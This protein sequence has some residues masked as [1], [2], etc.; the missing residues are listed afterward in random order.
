MAEG[1][2]EWLGSMTEY[3]SGSE[4]QMK[5]KWTIILMTLCTLMLFTGCGKQEEAKEPVV[6]YVSSV[7]V[8]YEKENREESVQYSE[9]SE[10]AASSE[11]E[12]SPE[13]ILP[14]PEPEVE[15]IMVGDILLHTPVAKSGKKEDGTY[16]FSHLFTNVKEILDGADLKLV[17]QEVIIGG[18][19]LG[20][21]G[22]PAF[23]APYELGD[24]LVDAGFNVVL[25]ATNHAMDKGKQGIKNCLSFWREKYPE[26][27]VLGI[28]DNEEDS[29]EIYYYEQEGITLAILNYTYGT[30]GI[31]LPQDMPYCVN[32]LDE[33][34]IKA[35]LKEA[36]EN[37]DFVIVC[38]HWGTEYLLESSKNQRK[39]AQFFADNGADAII[40]THPHVIEPFEVIETEDR[41]TYCFYSI[42][43]FVNWTS[44]TGEG[45]ANRMVG[46]IAKLIV[47]RNED[48]EVYLKEWNVIPVVS[49][50]E[51]GFGNVTVYPLVDYTEELGARSEIRK[52]DGKFSYQYCLDLVSKVFGLNLP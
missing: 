9:S 41:Q 29:K 49:H 18:A 16:D 17:N 4:M 36:K 38:P 34:R 52:Q 21:S 27:A 44:G 10:E 46:A 5:N 45:V 39:W 23:N 24:A 48:G 51:S 25:H 40:G 28:A 37:A 19:E 33:T 47:G 13:E 35:D 3:R 31:P 32:L 50:V 14:E 1:V 7:S 30:N 20:V 42:G 22:Y 26:I 15:L 11:P 12:E 8:E 2:V 43:N 6:G